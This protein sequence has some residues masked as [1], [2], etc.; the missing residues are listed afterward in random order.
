MV[1]SSGRS[2][3]Q[4][5]KLIFDIIHDE[6]KSFPKSNLYKVGFN[7]ITAEKWLDLIF[8]IQ[9]QPRI[10]LIKTT[11][12]TIIEKLEKKFSQ[13]SLQFFLDENQPIDKRLRSLEAYASSVL[14]QER[15]SK[16][17]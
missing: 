6:E 3:L 5:A 2:L 1:K 7:S 14:V 4:R 11:R 9:S 17:D 16:S 12:T 15:L 8:F 13:M 10:R